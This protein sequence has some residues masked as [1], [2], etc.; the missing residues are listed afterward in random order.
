MSEVRSKAVLSTPELH[1][2]LD[3]RTTLA[4]ATIGEEGERHLSAALF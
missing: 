2:L 1:Q 3:E 4:L